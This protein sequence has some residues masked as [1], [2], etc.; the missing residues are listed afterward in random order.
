MLSPEN[1]YEDSFSYLGK[2]STPELRVTMK[3]TSKTLSFDFLSKKMKV[4]VISSFACNER[5]NLG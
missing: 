5:T 3:V 2:G 4:R 1:H